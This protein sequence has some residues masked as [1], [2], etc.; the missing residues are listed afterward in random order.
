MLFLVIGFVSAF[1]I[2]ARGQNAAG[3][4]VI[5][6]HPAFADEN[7]VRRMEMA[8][9]NFAGIGNAEEPYAKAY[10]SNYVPAKITQP[11]SLLEMGKLIKNATSLMNR[12]QRSKNP[13]GQ[14]ILFWMYTGMKTVAEG[15]YHPPARINALLILGRMDA[16]PADQATQTPPRP[17]PNAL[18]ILIAQYNDEANLDGVRAA[19]LQG[20]RRY[21]MLAASQ[22][23]ANEK[24]SIETAMKDLLAADPPQNRSLQSHAYL[25]R[26]AVDILDALRPQQDATLGEQLISISTAK[27]KPDLIALHS[28]ARLGSMGAVMQG[29]VADPDPVLA[30][31]SVRA[32]AAFEAEVARLEGLTRPPK[33]RTQPAT[34]EEFL[35]NKREQQKSTSMATGDDESR[36]MMMMGDAEDMEDF[37]SDDSEMDEMMRMM[38]MS[39]GGA[40]AVAGAANPQPPEVIASRR[41]LNYVF[42]QIHLGVTGYPKTGMPNK[43][44]G[45]ILA[46]VEAEEDNKAKVEQWLLSIQPVVDAINDETLDKRESYLEGLKAQIEVLKTIS[47]AAE[48]KAQDDAA[49]DELNDL[50]AAPGGAKAAQP[51]D[52]LAAPAPVDPL[53]APAPVDPLVA[54]DPAAPKDELSLE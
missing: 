34:P 22:L 18:P 41:K 49:D 37:E 25:Q 7:T 3:F 1:A 10:Y 4:D 6:L 44:P 36:M 47:G 46:M 20:L 5:K 26:Y 8:A 38:M 24:T 33:A 17:L 16:S 27:E 52:P 54:P 50:L 12:A 9:R 43:K 13:R 14:K 2:Q 35:T 11:D 32:L 51:V 39:P 53:A 21:V 19:A 42:Q 30:S 48:Q 45:G 15:N 28:V 40:A 29:K 31:W 23:K